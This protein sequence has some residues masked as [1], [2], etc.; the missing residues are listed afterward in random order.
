MIILKLIGKNKIEDTYCLNFWLTALNPLRSSS[1]SSV[2]SRVTT[3]GELFTVCGASR[4]VVDLICT[5]HQLIKSDIAHARVLLSFVT[6]IL[7]NEIKIDK[8]ASSSAVE[9]VVSISH[10][11]SSSSSSSSSSK[12]QLTSHHKVTRD[13]VVS[14]SKHD[15]ATPTPI[16]RRPPPS[17]IVD[18]TD[19]DDAMVRLKKWSNSM[20]CLPC[21]SHQLSFYMCIYVV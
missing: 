19:I 9:A 12:P 4:D 8:L 5:D 14:S 7:A 1:S 21:L 3:I 16:S 18:R 17:A 15:N 2:L 20:S 13:T 11:S 6:V 10:E